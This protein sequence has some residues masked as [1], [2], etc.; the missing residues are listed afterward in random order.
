MQHTC[1]FAGTTSTSRAPKLG[2]SSSWSTTFFYKKPQV[3]VCTWGIFD[4]CLHFIPK[5]FV[6]NS[7]GAPF[8]VQRKLLQDKLLKPGLMTVCHGGRTRDNSNSKQL[9]IVAGSRPQRPRVACGAA[10]AIFCSCEQ[11]MKRVDSCEAGRTPDR[12]QNGLTRFKTGQRSRS[13][14]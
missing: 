1:S 10:S 5:C 6:E 14:P 8:A 9:A 13:G 4:S 12:F 7:A 3:L 11:V 2:M